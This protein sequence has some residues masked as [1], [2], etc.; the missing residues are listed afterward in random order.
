MVS[1]SATGSNVTRSPTSHRSRTS[2]SGRTVPRTWNAMATSYRIT[3]S[4]DG[5][6]ALPPLSP[7]GRQRW[8]VERYRV[9]LCGGERAVR[10]LDQVVAAVRLQAKHHEGET[11][12]LR[13]IEEPVKGH[14]RPRIEP[15]FALQVSKVSIGRKDLTDQQRVLD[16]NRTPIEAS[17][18]ENDDIG[19]GLAALVDLERDSVH[20]H[21]LR[22]T[23]LVKRAHELHQRKL[24]HRRT[25][26][27]HQPAIDKL[28]SGAAGKSRHHV[29]GPAAGHQKVAARLSH[30][31]GRMVK[32]CP[33]GA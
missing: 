4:V 9:G 30:D 16:R 10:G 6:D 21:E 18:L 1:E 22:R 13:T 12:R 27:Q 19:T 14:A 31:R 26:D 28:V 17:L 3:A 5:P 11:G 24:E 20:R 7:H 15:L 25:V 2:P 8:K 29:N 32:S 23:V 33:G